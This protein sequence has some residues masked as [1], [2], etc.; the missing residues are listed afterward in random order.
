MDTASTV[1]KALDTLTI[2]AGNGN[3]VPIP[4]LSLALNQPRSNVVRL[5]GSLRAYGLVTREGRS[6]KLTDAFREWSMPPDRY[7]ALRRRYRHVLEEAAAATGE[8][9][10]LGLHEGNGIIHIDYIESDGRVHLAPAPAT[11]HSIRYN[12]LGKL[13][14]SR[15]PDLAA[16]YADPEFQRELDEVRRTGIAWNREETVR[17]VIALAVPGFTNFPTE[18]MIAIAWPTMRFS[19]SAALQVRDVLREILCKTANRQPI[20]QE[21]AEVGL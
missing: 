17:G 11:R 14:L 7:T 13:A 16:N 20:E 10:L 4:E 1:L 15:R 12:A 9:V 8:L 5:L 6:W 18:P 19:E 2:L 3:G 21:L